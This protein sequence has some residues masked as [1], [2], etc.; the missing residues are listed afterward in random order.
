MIRISGRHSFLKVSTSEDTGEECRSDCKIMHSM[1]TNPAPQRKGFLT[2]ETFAA[3]L[4][5]L[6]PSQ[7]QSAGKYLELRKTLVG[8][9]VRKGCPHAEELTDRTL[10]RV[11]PIVHQ[12]P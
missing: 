9:F 8:Y 7:E 1:G 5:W 3:F 10:D 6:S 2:Q 11:A 12:E 4:L